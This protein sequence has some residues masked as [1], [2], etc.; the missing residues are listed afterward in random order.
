MGLIK[1]ADEEEF[2]MMSGGERPGG[3]GNWQLSEKAGGTGSLIP[4]KIFYPVSSSQMA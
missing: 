4:D 2:R 3:H 1:N